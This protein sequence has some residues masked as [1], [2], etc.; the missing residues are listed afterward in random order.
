[1]PYMNKKQLKELTEKAEEILQHLAVNHYYKAP[2]EDKIIQNTKDI[3]EIL[4]NG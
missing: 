2:N 3:L 1:M 4:K